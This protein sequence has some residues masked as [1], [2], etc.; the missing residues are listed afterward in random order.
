[1]KKYQFEELTAALS[2]IIAVLCYH[3]KIEWLFIIYVTKALLDT[4]TAIKFAYK[5]AV[6]SDR[7]RR[8]KSID[9]LK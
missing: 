4:I 9:K 5:S 2:I 1:M 6:K 7:K 3:F 8:A